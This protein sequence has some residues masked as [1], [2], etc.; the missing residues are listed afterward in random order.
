MVPWKLPA[1]LALRVARLAA[2]LDA[3][4]VQPLGVRLRPSCRQELKDHEAAVSAED[5]NQLAHHQNAD[6]RGGKSTDIFRAPGQP[7][8]D[9][10]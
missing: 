8:W 6:F 3:R 1:E 2:L 10:L 9:H 5:I 4:V 7:R